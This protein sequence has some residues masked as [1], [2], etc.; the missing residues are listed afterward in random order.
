M[1]AAQSGVSEN[2]VVNLTITS[3]VPT[4]NGYT[5]KGWSPTRSGS[6]SYFAGDK[7]QISGGNVTLYAVW[8]RS[9]SG[10]SGGGSGTSSGRNPKTGDES[11]LTLY[12]IL[13]IASLALVAVIAWWLLK[14]RKAAK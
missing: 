7:V 2:G 14:K 13:L 5:F 3:G 6:A 11:N 4:R 1:P 8:E 10:Y 9:G 12:M